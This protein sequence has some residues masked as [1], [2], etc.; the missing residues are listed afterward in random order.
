MT[1]VPSPPGR[2]CRSCGT[3]LPL[4]AFESDRGKRKRYK[5][6]HCRNMTPSKR[7]SRRAYMKRRRAK[8]KADKALIGST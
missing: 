7:A 2:L 6:M 4:T 5:C 8:L 3:I 1:P